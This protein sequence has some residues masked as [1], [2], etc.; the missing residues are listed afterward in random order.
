MNETTR[1]TDA[2]RATIARAREVRAAPAPSLYELGD[3]AARIAALE[4]HLDNLLAVVDRLDG[5]G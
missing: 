4:W 2:D 1:L 5:H 3:M